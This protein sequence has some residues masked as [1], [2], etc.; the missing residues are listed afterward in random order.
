MSWVNTQLLLLQDNVTQALARGE[1]AAYF[2]LFSDSIFPYLLCITHRHEP[3]LGGVLHQRLEAENLATNSVRTSIEWTYGDV[4]VLFHVLH[5]KYNK[6][7]FLPDRTIN[8][9][10]HQQLRVVFFIYKCYVCFNGNKL[11]RF[12]DTP[13]PKLSDYLAR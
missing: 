5:S 6:K 8:Q 4:V 12:F 2:A 13:P 3:P 10:L 7:Y 1:D 9:L 11:T